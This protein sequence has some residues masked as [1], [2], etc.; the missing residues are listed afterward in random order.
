MKFMGNIAKGSMIRGMTGATIYGLWIAAKYIFCNSNPK[1]GLRLGY[2]LMGLE[3]IRRLNEIS[4]IRNRQN[5]ILEKV[6]E[7]NEEEYTTTVMILDLLSMRYVQIE[8][9]NIVLNENKDNSEIVITDRANIVNTNSA[10]Y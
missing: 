10:V 1:I 3:G 8:M 2:T 5:W 6:F 4:S 7:G 9:D